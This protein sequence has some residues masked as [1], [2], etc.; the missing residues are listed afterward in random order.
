MTIAAYDECLTSTSTP[1]PRWM[2]LK[3]Q[4]ILS[5]KVSFFIF[6]HS[7]N[8]FYRSHQSPQ[9]APPQPPFW[10]PQ[11]FQWTP[12]WPPLPRLTMETA[13]WPHL[14]TRPCTV[15]RQGQAWLAQGPDFSWPG[16]TC[17]GSRAK[18][19]DLAQP[20]PTWSQSNP[21]LFKSCKR[22]FVKYRKNKWK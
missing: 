18:S 19:S 12:K 5:S 13:V 15:C 11:C 16:P 9:W 6:S 4:C 3:M 22:K 8:F 17:I 2:V 7:T 1:I 20:G 10:P 21:T 14:S